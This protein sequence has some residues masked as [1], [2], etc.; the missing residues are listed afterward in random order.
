ME[1]LGARIS[2]LESSEAW[3]RQD[4]DKAKKERDRYL[5]DVCRLNIEVSDLKKQCFEANE[6][7]R[8]Y[9]SAVIIDNDG[10][11]VHIKDLPEIE[12]PAELEKEIQASLDRGKA[13][14][15]DSTSAL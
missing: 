6:K 12:I 11:L 9:E 7:I 13:P 4:A 14:V 10:N 15:K 8:E 3:A 1:V 5:D 2:S